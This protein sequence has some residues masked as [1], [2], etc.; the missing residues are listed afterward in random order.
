MIPAILMVLIIALVPAAL[1]RLSEKIK[2]FKTLGTVF[3]CYAA[4]IILSFPMKVLGAQLT[5]ASSQQTHTPPLQASGP[6]GRG[7]S[8]G[9]AW[10]FSGEGTALGREGSSRATPGPQ[11]ASPPTGPAFREAVQKRRRKK[12]IS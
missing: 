5:L 3:L 6:W 1:M 9:V 4:G 12:L 11:A 2:L 10:R 7:W 8:W